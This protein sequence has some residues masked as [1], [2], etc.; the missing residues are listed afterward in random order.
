MARSLRFYTENLDF[1]IAPWD[2]ADSPVIDLL[3]DGAKMQLCEFDGTPGI[4]LNVEVD[5]VDELFR[6]YLER[7][8]DP[9]GKPNSPVHQGPVDQTWGT[10]E[11][12]VTDPD[13][14][15]LRFRAFPGS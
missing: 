4:A 10:R 9:S 3:R 12:Y 11:F 7:G 1:E 14:N 15:T 8:L 13:G 5:E 2:D 6:S